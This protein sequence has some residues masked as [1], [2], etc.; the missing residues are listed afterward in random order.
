MLGTCQG[1]FLGGESLLLP[2]EG[3]QDI[4]GLGLHTVALYRPCVP[5]PKLGV[6][7]HWLTRLRNI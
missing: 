2:L 4:G 1:A 7:G 5:S 3:A 6:S